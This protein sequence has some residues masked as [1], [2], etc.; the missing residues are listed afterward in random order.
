MDPIATNRLESRAA[1]RLICEAC[2]FEFSCDPTGSCWCLE[3]T[4]R[5]PM[6]VEGQAGRFSDCLCRDCLRSIGKEQTAAPQ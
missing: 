2:G 6:P 5:L 1:R 3:E 4:I